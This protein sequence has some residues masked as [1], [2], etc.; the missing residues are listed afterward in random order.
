MY[1]IRNHII[2]ARRRAQRILLCFNAIKKFPQKQTTAMYSLKPWAPV[3]SFF[4][5]RKQSDRDP[6]GAE[7]GTPQT[8][9]KG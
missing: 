9:N 3:E 8:L 7:N 4:K 5:G 6:T 2:A 1:F